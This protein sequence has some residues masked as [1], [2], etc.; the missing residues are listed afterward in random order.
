MT[1]KNAGTASLRISNIAITGTNA[2]NF[3]QTYTCGSSL[4]AGAS[5]TISVKF[6]PT[7]SGTRYAALSVTG[8]AAGN[9]HKV[10]LSGIGTTAKLSPTSLNFGSVGLGASLVKTVTLKNVGT[11]RLTISGIAISGT[12]G[13]DF[14]QTH[15]CGSSLGAG[16]SC[17][18]SVTFKPVV[19]R[20]RAAALHVTDNAAGSP[21]TV[22]LSGIGVSGGTLTGYCLSGNIVPLLGCRV[23][24]DPSECSPG[25]PAI[26]PEAT[27]CGFGDYNDDGATSCR[28][29]YT[30]GDCLFNPSS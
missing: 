15:T 11:T 29:P 22:A 1:L 8:N 28:G 23:T 18:I 24:Y 5:C 30:R 4:P 19:L 13:G 26:K 20:T 14:V 17:I 21:Q 12:N 7:V 16:A 6:K 27:S 25:K 2:G 10:T 9:P 3:V